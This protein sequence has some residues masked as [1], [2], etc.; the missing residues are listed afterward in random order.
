M[1]TDKSEMLVQFAARPLRSKFETRSSYENR[2][3]IFRIS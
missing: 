2:Q 3:T 1:V